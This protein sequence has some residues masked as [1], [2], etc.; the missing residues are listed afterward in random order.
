MVYMARG[1]EKQALGCPKCRHSAGG[2]GT[3]RAKASG[4][5]PKPKAPA[6]SSGGHS[7]GK[8][9]P[10]A[11][12]EPPSEG[13]TIEVEIA[14]DAG[15]TSWIKAKVTAVQVDGSFSAKITTHDDQWDDWFTWSEE[16]TDWRRKSR[17]SSRGGGRS[18]SE[19]MPST[20]LRLRVDHRRREAVLLPPL[21]MKRL[22][23]RPAR[24]QKAIRFDVLEG[25]LPYVS[26]D[27]SLVGQRVRCLTPELRWAKGS[28]AS[29]RGNSRFVVRFDKV[30][31][32]PER[33]EEMTL[34]DHRVELLVD[35]TPFPPLDEDDAED[36]FVE[37]EEPP[38][39]AARK[40]PRASGRDGETSGATGDGAG[41][42]TEEGAPAA[43][44]EA[45]AE[46]SAE[47]VVDGAKEND[48]MEVCDPGGED[49]DADAPAMCG[50]DGCTLRAWHTGMCMPTVRPEEESS[51]MR[52]SSRRASAPT[53][54]PAPE[55]AAETKPMK[56]DA[57][58]DAGDEKKQIRLFTSKLAAS[59]FRHVRA[60][61]Y[62]SGLTEWVEPA[63]VAEGVR[64][65]YVAQFWSAGKQQTLGPVDTAM[66]AAT[67]YTR[68]VIAEFE[69]EAAAAAAAEAKA[70]ARAAA[71]AA[72][73]EAAAA[74]A[75]TAR[76]A[77][78]AAAEAA[79]DAHGMRLTRGLRGAASGGGA[80]L[81]DAERA[82]RAE[83]EKAERAALAER[84]EQADRA[85]YFAAN[86]K[87]KSD[88]YD[89]ELV[90]RRV[91]ATRESDGETSVGTIFER[92]VGAKRSAASNYKVR[93]DDGVI[94]DLTLPDDGVEL[95]PKDHGDFDESSGRSL[96]EA[97]K[98]W[99][100]AAAEEELRAKE[101]QALEGLTLHT[102]SKSDTGYRCVTS[103][104]LSRL[105]VFAYDV[106]ATKDGRCV[107]VGRFKSKLQAAVAFARFISSEPPSTTFGNMVIEPVLPESTKEEGINTVDKIL[108]VR[109]TVVDCLEP[110]DFQEDGLPLTGDTAQEWGKA[111]RTKEAIAALAAGY[112]IEQ[113]LRIPRR[114]KAS[115]AGAAAGI[116]QESPL[117]SLGAPALV[118]L[119][120]AAGAQAAESLDSDVADAAQDGDAAEAASQPAPEGAMDV[121][122]QD[123]AAAE[124]AAGAAGGDSGREEAIASRAKRRGTPELGEI[125]QVE[126]EEEGVINWV[127]A[128][129][130]QVMPS[131]RFYVCVGND[132]DFIESYGLED[133]FK[134]WR[135][136]GRLNDISEREIS[137]VEVREMLVKLR[138][139]SYLRSKW[140]TVP[141]IEADGGLSVNILK[142]F[143]KRLEKGESDES[144]K[145]HMGIERIVSHRHRRGALEYL[146]KP[147]GLSY[148]ECSWERAPQLTDPDALE[149][150]RRYLAASG[151]TPASL[152]GTDM[153]G[154][155]TAWLKAGSQLEIA[156]KSRHGG[157]WTTAKVLQA[158]DT[159]VLIER[160]NEVPPPDVGQTAQP[161]QQGAG[162]S[163]EQQGEGVEAEQQGEEASA[164]Q[165]GTKA[166]AEQQGGEAELEQQGMDVEAEQGA[167]A[168][169]DTKDAND[170]S[171]SA[172]DPQKE[173]QAVASRA[174]QLKATVRERL[175]LSRMRPLPPRTPKDF[176]PVNEQAVQ[177][178]HSTGWWAGVVKSVR[179]KG[180]QLLDDDK[181]FAMRRELATKRAAMQASLQPPQSAEEL[182]VG[183]RASG[184]DGKQ[185]EV[186]VADDDGAFHRWAPVRG[187]G[188]GG[189][190]GSK[191]RRCGACAGCLAENC[192][193]CKYCLDMPKFG[194]RGVM[195]Q[196]CEKR[197]CVSL[198]FDDDGDQFRRDD[199]PATARATARKA[200]QDADTSGRRSSRQP[201]VTKLEPP[202]GGEPNALVKGL[203]PRRAVAG[204]RVVVDYEEEDESGAPINVRYPGTVL[205]YSVT[206]GLLVRFDSSPDDD[207]TW[208][209]EAGDDEWE[210]E[211]TTKA[212]QPPQPDQQPEANATDKVEPTRRSGRRSASKQ[213]EEVVQTEVS[214]PEMKVEEEGEACA[215]CGIA[216]WAP[217]N[218]MLLCDGPGCEAAYHI[219]C[220]RPPLTSVPQ[221]DWFCP[222]CQPNSSAP[223]SRPA[224]QAGGAQ[225]PAKSSDGLIKGK[226]RNKITGARIVVD[227]EE[228]G[229]DGKPEIK[230]YPGVVLAYSSEHGLLV[231]FDGFDDDDEEGEAWVEEAGVDDW[232]W[233]ESAT[234]AAKELTCLVVDAEGTEFWRPLKAL[235]PN[236]VWWSTE[237]GWSIDDDEPWQK[238]YDVEVEAADEQEEEDD[239][240][241]T[242]E[243]EA[244][245]A[246]L[247][248]GETGE[249]DGAEPNSDES[250]AVEGME[251]EESKPNED[252]D[253]GEDEP[254]DEAGLLRK[255]RHARDD[256][257]EED[258]EEGQDDDESEEDEPT[259]VTGWSKLDESPD[260]LC[261][262]M[263]LRSYQLDGLNW[264]R[265]SYYLGRN[266]ILGDEMGLG[267]TAQSVSMLQSLRS[268]EGI[269]GPFLI[270]AP[271]ST[272]PHWER[273][274]SQ[275][276]D[277][278]WVN[279]HGTADA[280]RVVQQYEWLVDEKAPRG[281]EKYRFHVLLANYETVIQEPD[282]LVAVRW[283]Y[284]IVDEGHRLKNRNSRCLEVM[285]ELRCKR[286][287]VLSGTPLQNHVAE[288]WSMLNFLEPNKFTGGLG[289]DAFL[290]RFGSLSTGGGTAKQV[291]QLNKLIRPHLLRREKEDVEQSLP[292]MKETL[293][294]VEI[295][296]L[297]KMCYR[298][299]LERNRE[300]LLRGAG[301]AGI[302]PSF[303]NISMMLRHCC[304]HPWLISDV[305][306]G[307]LLDL[308]QLYGRAPEAE[309]SA[310][311]TERLIQ[312]SGKFVLL[313]KL[314]PKLKSE[315]HRVL[316][317]SQFTKVLD[318]FEDLLEA[319]G[320]G[321]ERL[322]GSV[323]GVARQQAID[324]FSNPE[325]DCFVFMLS[326]RAGGVGINLTAADRVIVFDPDWNPQNDVQA[327][328]RCHRIGQTKA[329]QV[330][331]LCTKGTYEN[332]MLKLANQK[333]GLEHAIM[334]T[335]EHSE[336]ALTSTG[337]AKSDKGPFDAATA[338]QRASQI[339]QLL[340]NGAQLLMSTEQDQDAVAFGESSIEDILQNYVET[341]NDGDGDGDGDGAG[342]SK[343]VV[344]SR[345]AFSQ[346]TV[347]SEQGS[348]ISMDDPDFW[349]KML[350]DDG[351]AEA[352]DAAAK[353]SGADRIK[354]LKF[355]DFGDTELKES[356]PGRRKSSLGAA[357]PGEADG[358]PDAKPRK[359]RAPP[360]TRT[361]IEAVRDRIL[362]V[363]HAAAPELEGDGG[364]EL[365]G[366]QLLAQRCLAARDI[367]DV[368]K[369]CD[370]V[371]VA[372]LLHAPAELTATWSPMELHTVGERAIRNMGDE[373]K[374]KF[375]GRPPKRDPQFQVSQRTL[376]TKAGGEP[377]P[378]GRAP[379]TDRGDPLT[380]SF[381]RGKWVDCSKGGKS[382]VKGVPQTPGEREEV[383]AENARFEE[384]M[385]E[386]EQK[387][388]EEW[389]EHQQ[390]LA[391]PPPGACPACPPYLL[392]RPHTCKQA[393]AEPDAAAEAKARAKAEPT[394]EAGAEAEAGASVGAEADVEMADAD[395]GVDAAQGEEGV[396]EDTA[397]RTRR[398]LEQ[399]EA[400]LRP[401]RDAA[402]WLAAEARESAGRWLE[403]L[404]EHRK[405]DDEE[406]IKKAARARAAGRKRA[407]EA[408]DVDESREDDEEEHKRAREAD[409][410]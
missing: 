17:R 47:G 269:Q 339:E 282:A 313:Q 248:R 116:P 128:E 259:E 338:T 175:P 161:E 67:A 185:W 228:N 236:W 222:K 396:A 385:R 373:V 19:S 359:P 78:A 212:E 261:N 178:A 45:P 287:L 325:S 63:A 361:E 277:M 227:Y 238:I 289:V 267:K 76:A 167:G 281:Q 6:R 380:W 284:L 204:K 305:E 273:E 221:G 280:R 247:L 377:R 403:R 24:G 181:F 74:H 69:E 328:A 160:K 165:Q 72:A 343:D 11:D 401:T 360:F 170:G 174:P 392:H 295:T 124:S 89:D 329:V 110:S 152:Q 250:G 402:E 38:E 99:K 5:A 184:R 157:E 56:P 217:G 13:D 180:E 120:A 246:A 310:R 378:K 52:R 119:T 213:P 341:I 58:E 132:E 370:Y 59:G 142:K 7:G 137:K 199:A 151:H 12:W 62:G 406:E 118:V 156:G 220:L 33:E 354:G 320:W 252:A 398:A 166:E 270:V 32:Q 42:S 232:D 37:E 365:T 264:M 133:E 362:A 294:Y 18:S 186:V 195:R 60:V 8:T 314:L 169:S 91:R 44:D 82:E 106:R 163:G 353:R 31:K 394:A 206:D 372:T 333:L 278:Y 240:L 84:L 290:E 405:A 347:V 340:K 299:V 68:F 327:M 129:V 387:M 219:G 71:K 141:E 140:M 409:S 260:F 374:P 48:A 256:D 384:S 23:N 193:S 66:E 292:G 208:V 126:I 100:A 98:A 155:G 271:L 301:T 244:K 183:K 102:S 97:R 113:V 335:G 245:A 30:K 176:R 334:R 154:T 323:S 205:A 390:N 70:A 363:G 149:S 4:E 51:E 35:V 88:G 300:L 265:L 308:D 319:E 64:L 263:K 283:Q 77:K 144:Y 81:T 135:R 324:R 2:C 257:Y 207:P 103:Q 168:S 192:G 87:K 258:G 162:T 27:E 50:R 337:F 349:S 39:R 196:T 397:A 249:E 345:S 233:E 127:D 322:D 123:A 224:S 201:A 331:K 235:R 364:G 291:A 115:V 26:V 368:R 251:V 268:I 293:L 54:V 330:Y 187:M 200:A 303:N 315:G 101:D 96:E 255:P 342:S 164:E 226:R 171:P 306:E 93:Y 218:E 266:I 202:D 108:D 296:N 391:P 254:E 230:R 371:L 381:V 109:V 122:G 276:T 198:K 86:Q 272:L 239:L 10:P 356:G 383:L 355:T 131:N 209:D 344:R 191:R 146:V 317:F 274:L 376:V 302:G 107:H 111:R 241:T 179:K 410:D 136:T 79:A 393:G 389:K 242:A 223:S 188:K 34:L 28:L 203:H 309:R 139:Y 262:G 148:A 159:D 369:A 143:E 194:G 286:K 117:A 134:E 231:R 312:S 16:D 15:A 92:A 298:A 307:A 318:L 379:H 83:R 237:E 210:W 214:A 408:A 158:G 75:A 332:H 234:E 311:Y 304:N 25:T 211:E 9:G 57:A 172:E 375:G 326:T 40:K 104:Y 348:T 61:P 177:V 253:G 95:Q 147:V 43:A 285:N 21:E 346:A 80:P 22:S 53:P 145:K 321:F 90:G 105:A 386:I 367:R 352:A 125:V 138:G 279:F 215:S 358:G 190:G 336:R 65:V 243:R 41:T 29:F 288:L 130:R 1:K 3:C 114:T 297:Q 275:W 94:E 55:P 14:D 350:P 20:K 351:E 229:D 225:A 150:I 395:A 112:S 189:S 153:H 121:D 182:P 357:R 197:A 382:T 366:E 73:A 388:F 216:L 316:F 36:C 85:A 407:R 400:K 49:E 173:A 46:T 404:L 399:L